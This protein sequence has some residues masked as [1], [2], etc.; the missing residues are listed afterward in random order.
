MSR[1]TSTVAIVRMRADYYLDQTQKKIPPARMRVGIF[2][3][4]RRRL[5]T[6]NLDDADDLRN[7]CN[8]ASRFLQLSSEA[9]RQPNRREVV[10]IAITSKRQ[11]CITQIV[12]H[13]PRT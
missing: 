13:T 5:I 12:V 6:N 7:V 1:T 2:G 3:F 10:L 4:L 9:V 11:L 8:F